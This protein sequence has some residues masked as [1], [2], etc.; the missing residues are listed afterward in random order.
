MKLAFD[1]DG[2]LTNAPGSNFVKGMSLQSSADLGFDI[3]FDT[4]FID[5]ISPIIFD[6]AVEPYMA[7]LADGPD[8][9][10]PR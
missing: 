8:V 2:V 1:I 3:N 5:D 4:N 9:D 10:G 7:T 6:L